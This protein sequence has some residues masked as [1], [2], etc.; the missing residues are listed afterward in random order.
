LRASATRVF[1]VSAAR[2]VGSRSR[3]FATSQNV[4][5]TA[6]A[7]RSSRLSPIAMQSSGA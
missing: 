1:A 3:P 2:I 7:P 6:A 4:R 5:T